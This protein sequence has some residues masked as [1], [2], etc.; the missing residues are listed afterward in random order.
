MRAYNRERRRNPERLRRANACKRF[1]R[2]LVKV[3][4][5]PR[6]TTKEQREQRLLMIEAAMRVQHGWFDKTL[7]AE[8]QR[9]AG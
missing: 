9:D 2:L 8:E 6:G 7:K 4:Q 5:A 3:G 1:N